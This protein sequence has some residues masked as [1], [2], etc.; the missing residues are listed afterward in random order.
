MVPAICHCPPPRLYPSMGVPE[1][2][3]ARIHP[4]HS[5]PA[6]GCQQSRISG[7]IW[8]GQGIQPVVHRSDLSF[9][10]VVAVIG[11][12]KLAVFYD[13]GNEKSGKSRIMDYRASS[14]QSL[15]RKV[16]SGLPSPVFLTILSQT[17]S[18]NNRQIFSILVKEQT[19]QYH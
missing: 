7:E 6:P 16:R 5:T 8:G 13:L 4:P 3:H 11:S 17:H 18:P 14:G 10:M 12:A 19:K 15:H 2:S 9:Y 1:T